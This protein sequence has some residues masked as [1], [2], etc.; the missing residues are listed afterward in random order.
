MLFASIRL[1]FYA[2]LFLI[3]LKIIG[4]P[5]DPFLILLPLILGVIIGVVGLVLVYGIG[6]PYI[7]IREWYQK[8]ERLEAEEYFKK[9]KEFEKIHP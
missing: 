6:M 9:Q 4:F 7:L 3:L 8:Q 2:F 1:G 5:I